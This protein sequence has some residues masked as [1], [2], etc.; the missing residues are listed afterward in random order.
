MYYADYHMHSNNSTDA[1]D[2]MTDMARASADFGLSE[3]CFT[4]HCDLLTD[5]LVV[6][7][8][9]SLE[10]L[11][12]QYKAALLTCGSRIKIKFGLELGQPLSNPELADK[13]VNSDDLDF[14]I[15]SI[16]V[17]PELGD[18]YYMEY[19]SPEQ[20]S[21][22]ISRYLDEVEALA[23]WGNFDVLG[24]LT[25]PIRYM[26]RKGIKMDFS[27][28][29]DRVRSLYR[30]LIESGM[31]IE[32]NMSNLKRPGGET[33]PDLNL[34]KLYKDCGGEIIT[35]GS[36]AHRADDAGAFVPRGCDLLGYAGFRY[37]CVY[38]HRKPE[39]IKI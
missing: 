15:G 5:E 3:I 34:L 28:F 26:H 7:N 17:L 24:H 16:H 10:P 27:A 1:R 14:I 9:F 12:E 22:I 32:L 37:Y 29:T 33:M 31:G 11:R 25:Y 18:C 2:T 6:L 36:D 4:D 39:F 19:D 20:C 38:D 35:V 13:L 8:D 21:F 30:L 23:K